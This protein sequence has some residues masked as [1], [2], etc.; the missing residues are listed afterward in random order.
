MVCD[1]MIK[2]LFGFSKIDAYYIIIFTQLDF[3][4]TIYKEGRIYLV[5]YVSKQRVPLQSFL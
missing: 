4:V 3:A 2:K 1:E 5:K